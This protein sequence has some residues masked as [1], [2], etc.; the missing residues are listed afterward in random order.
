MPNFEALNAQKIGRNLLLIMKFRWSDP[1]MK[2]K[3]WNNGTKRPKLWSKSIL[4]MKLRG[5]DPQ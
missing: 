2:F 5:S 1:L 4:I 3:G